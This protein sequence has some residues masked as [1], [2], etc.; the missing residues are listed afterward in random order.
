MIALKLA[1]AAKAERK[2]A[3]RVRTLMVAWRRQRTAR[4]IACELNRLNIR[5]PCGCQW[6]REGRAGRVGGDRRVE[7]WQRM[8]EA[9][10]TRALAPFS[11][12]A[13]L[14]RGVVDGAVRKHA[15][16]ANEDGRAERLGGSG[17]AFR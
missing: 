1:N 8:D 15:L 12:P 16:A 2:P 5:A 14:A 4:A 17:C 11:A 9:T 7:H 10:R 3:A 6:T 13:H